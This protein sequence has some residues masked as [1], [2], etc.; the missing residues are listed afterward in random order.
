MKRAIRALITI[1]ISAY[2]ITAAA[3]LS[4]SY[5]IDA[6]TSTGGTNFN[7]FNDFADTLN[8]AGVSGPVTAEVKPGSGPY[9]E[10]VSFDSVA[11]TSAV[12]TITIK[13]NLNTITANPNI[14]NKHIIR[15]QGTDHMI[16]DSLVIKPDSSHPDYCWS[17]HLMN[18]A[19]SNV[20]SNCIIQ[21]YGSYVTSVENICILMNGSS[22]YYNVGYSYGNNHNRI[23]GSSIA[24]AFAGFYSNG[25]SSTSGI[26][27]GTIIDNNTISQCWT[28]TLFE[29]FHQNT[30]F[31][32]NRVDNC[33][34]GFRS[35]QHHDTL[36]ILR[37]F[38]TNCVYGISENGNHNQAIV[39]D[40]YID[41]N[42]KGHADWAT[43]STYGI[44]GFGH[45]HST[46]C[47][48]ERNKIVSQYYG[49]YSGYYASNC[50]IKNN[51]ITIVQGG[52]H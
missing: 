31:T 7:S 28:G 27:T 11:G 35:H 38:L 51:S 17:V 9:Y 22:F 50:E 46:H 20:I 41:L 45:F 36:Q 5:T 42:L 1:A 40:N 2:S 8:I 48:V 29:F 37:N 16:I 25:D 4:G 26:T 44:Y 34:R 24:N 43:H 13:G 15:L 52:Y 10:Q 12:N 21:S 14:S 49:I 32:D 19:D 30:K 39:R 18:G 47:I 6:G 33:Y 3:Q 23:T